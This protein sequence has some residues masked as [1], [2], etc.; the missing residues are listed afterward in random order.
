MH[1]PYHNHELEINQSFCVPCEIC[2]Q[3]FELSCSDTGKHT[4]TNRLDL[5]TSFLVGCNYIKVSPTLE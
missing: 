5:K 3:H 1:D 4:H 2:P